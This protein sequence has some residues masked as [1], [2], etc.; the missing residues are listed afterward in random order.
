MT[1]VISSFL[2]H[3]QFISSHIAIHWFI[4][5]VCHIIVYDA[6]EMNWYVLFRQST[7]LERPWRGHQVKWLAV[8]WCPPEEAE[9]PPVPYPTDAPGQGTQPPQSCQTPVEVVQYPD[10]YR[11]G[12]TAADSYLSFRLEP[13]QLVYFQVR[14]DCSSA[15]CAIISSKLNTNTPSV[16]NEVHLRRAFISYENYKK[17]IVSKNVTYICCKLHTKI[18]LI[19][20]PVFLFLTM[21]C[22]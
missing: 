3:K 19:I 20:K 5:F 18:H 14:W 17:P 16:V 7:K 4:L 11:F 10:V 9:L 21:K 22:K 12:A 2:L 8:E 13:S 1:L 15:L 6:S